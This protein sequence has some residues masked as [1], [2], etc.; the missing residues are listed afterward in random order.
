MGKLVGIIMAKE[1]RA[2]GGKI[3]EGETPT[4]QFVSLC[5]RGTRGREFFVIERYRAHAIEKPENAH[6]EFEDWRATV[7][8][9]LCIVFCTPCPCFVSNSQRSFDKAFASFLI[10]NLMHQFVL[11]EF[12]RTIWGPMWCPPEA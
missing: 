10:A 6:V 5:A 7:S 2:K 1:Q 11:L 12:W 4:I 9:R 8:A 3:F